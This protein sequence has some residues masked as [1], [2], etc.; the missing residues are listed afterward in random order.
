[1]AKDREDGAQQVTTTSAQRAWNIEPGS[2]TGETYGT[3]T[4]NISTSSLTYLFDIGSAIDRAHRVSIDEVKQ[5][6]QGSDDI[7]EQSG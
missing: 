1:M 3:T 2:L 5:P 6:W 7:N 4:S